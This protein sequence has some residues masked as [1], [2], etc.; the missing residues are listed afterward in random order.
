MELFS[1]LPLFFS[2]K[3]I[4]ETCCSVA[5]TM[6]SAI[7]SSNF[8]SQMQS[9]RLFCTKKLWQILCIPHYEIV[10]ARFKYHTLLWYRIY[11]I[12][13]NIWYVY[14][15][16]FQKLCRDQTLSPRVWL[17]RP[18]GTPRRTFCPVPVRM[19]PTSS[20]PSTTLL[21]VATTPSASLKV[22]TKQ[23]WLFLV[24]AEVKSIHKSPCR[25]YIS[26]ILKWFK[27]LE[28]AA[29]KKRRWIP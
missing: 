7:Q 20:L 6:T 13:V 28:D 9:I 19:T 21:L 4:K 14:C 8:I 22:S 24:M 12:D 16:V 2:L 5:I 3:N 29:A 18:A 15:V 17:K 26:V 27:L 25:T 23:S 11:P 10:I 1:S